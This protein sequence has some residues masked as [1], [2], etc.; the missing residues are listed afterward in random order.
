MPLF[1]EKTRGIYRSS[2]GKHLYS[3]VYVETLNICNKN[4]SFCHGTKRTPKIMSFEEFSH[5]AKSLVGITKYIYFHLMGE[6][7]CHPELPKFIEYASSLGFFCAVTTNGTLLDKRGEE[8]IKAGVYK[9]NISLHSFE[10][11]DEKEKENYL[12]S[13]LDFADKASSAKILTILRLWN[14]ER[15][16][17]EN[18]EVIDKIKARF[19]DGEWVAGGRGI[20][21]KDKLHI[22]YGER[23]V[24]PD[25]QAPEIGDKVFCYGLS[26]HFGI[27][28]DGSVVPCCL[29]S[30]G[31]M[32]LGNVHETSLPAILSSERAEIIRKSF[33]KCE[34]KEE[35]CKKCSYARRF[36]IK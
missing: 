13:C 21:V 20:R 8:L 2:G 28:A 25:I 35:L 31:V 36:K 18:R 7:L 30:D 33:E 12:S 10:G 29:D 15:D 32:T 26:D 27:L 17:G 1:I 3:R 6:P 14:S 16:N 9:V 19:S 34:A 5:I 23:F 24:W 11:E 4:C 22:E